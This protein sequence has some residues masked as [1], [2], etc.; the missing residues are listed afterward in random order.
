MDGI[1]KLF[2]LF[3]IELII[4]FPIVTAFTISQPV[5]NI[6]RNNVDISWNTS[7]N[8]NYSFLWDVSRTGY[9][10]EKS[11]SQFNT[12]HKVDLT[13]LISGESYSYQIIAWSNH[14]LNPLRQTYIGSFIVP[15]DNP[16]PQITGAR[17]INATL[18]YVEIEW[19]LLDRNE[20]TDLANYLIFRN[21]ENIANVT[22]SPFKD[23]KN[24]T[25]LATYIYTIAAS[26]V[27]GSIGPPSDGII[28]SIPEPDLTPPDLFNIKAIGMSNTSTLIHWT[29]NK[30]ADSTVYYGRHS[31]NMT[32]RTSGYR[33]NHTVTL[34]RLEGGNTYRY[35]VQSCDKYENCR[36][37]SQFSFLAGGSNS[38]P[39]LSVSLPSNWNA[40]IMPINGTTTPLTRVFVFVNDFNNPQF[41]VQSDLDGKFSTSVRFP[42]LVSTN[43]VLIRAMD[44]SGNTAERQF[45][46]QVD[47]TKPIVEMSEIPPLS[48]VASLPI[49][50][51]ISKDVTLNIYVETDYIGGIPPPSQVMNLVNQSVN[52]NS[53][54]LRWDANNRSEDIQFYRIYRN[55][56]AIGTSRST[57]FSDCTMP[58]T[59]YTY[60][61]AAVN[62]NCDEGAFSNTVSVR[63]PAGTNCTTSVEYEDSCSSDTPVRSIRINQGDFRQSIPL[64]EGSN[65]IRL[66]F[67]DAGGNKVEVFGTTIYDRKDPT[68]TWHNLRDLTPAY[69]DKVTVRG[70][71]DEPATVAVTVNNDSTFIGR[72][73]SNGNFSIEIELR[74]YN[75]EETTETTRAQDQIT[76]RVT[77]YSVLDQPGAEGINRQNYYS[78]QTGGVDFETTRSTWIADDGAFRNRVEIMAT[79]AVGRNSTVQR[80]DIE[81]RMCSYGSYWG[82]NLSNPMPSMLNPRHLLTGVAQVTFNFDLEWL[83]GT[84]SFVD[85][86][87]PR[88]NINFRFRRISREDQADWDVG[89]FNDPP[90][91]FMVPGSNNTQ[92]YVV[93]QSKALDRSATDTNR[94][95]RDLERA[96]RE[97]EVEDFETLLQKE[98]KISD[99]RRGSDWTNN[100]SCMISQFGCVR[101]PVQIEIRFTDPVYQ[102]NRDNLIGSTATSSGQITQ[103]QCIDFEIAI[104]RR[105]DTNVIPESF[106]RTAIKFLNNTIQLIDNLLEPLNKIKEYTLYACMGSWVVMYVKA[107]QKRWNCEFGG[108]NIKDL[109]TQ[110]G[111]KSIVAE[112]GLCEFVYAER[113]SEGGAFDLSIDDNPRLEACLK[114]ANATKDFWDWEEKMQLLCDR[115]ACPSAPSF[116]KYVRDAQRDRGRQQSV[117]IQLDGPD[118]ATD[119]LSLTSRSDCAGIELS[120]EFIQYQ[121]QI[122]KKYKEEGRDAVLFENPY[123]GVG[124]PAESNLPGV[125]GLDTKKVSCFDPRTPNPNCCVVE[126]MRKY[127]SVCGLQDGFL[128]DEMEESYCVAASFMAKDTLH[129]TETGI[130][131][132]TPDFVFG[133]EEVDV[134]GVTEERR[135]IP[136]YSGEGNLIGSGDDF[137]GAVDYDKLCNSPARRTW[138][139]L[140][141]ICE[142]NPA[143][144][145][146]IVDT[147]L[148]YATES[149]GRYFTRV[150]QTPTTQTAP[151]FAERYNFLSAQRADPTVTVHNTIHP[152]DA[153][154]FDGAHTIYIDSDCPQTLRS[155]DEH[156]I[157][158]RVLPKRVQTAAGEDTSFDIAGEFIVHRG[159]ILQNIDLDT[160]VVGWNSLLFTDGQ[161]DSPV[162]ANKVFRPLSEI[163]V[164]VFKVPEGTTIDSDS[165]LFN[166]YINPTGFAEFKRD[167]NHCASSGD[168]SRMTA[169]DRSALVRDF[170]AYKQANKDRQIRDLKE[171][172]RDD[173][174]NS[175]RVNGVT[176]S[177]IVA[178]HDGCTDDVLLR[179]CNIS[180]DTEVLS[181]EFAKIFQEYEVDDRRAQEIYLKIQ[182]AL[183]LADKEKIVDPSSSFLRSVQCLCLPGITGYLKL[184]KAI[185]TAVKACLET[186]LIT[187]DG[188]PGI[189]RAVLTRYVCDLIYDLIKC[190]ANKYSLGHQRTIGTDSTPGNI[191]GALTSAG[192]DVQRSIAGRYGSSSLFR[193]MF[194]ERQLVHA[195][196]LWAFTGTFDFD[197]NA[198]VEGEFGDIPVDSQ[199]LLSPCQR[200]F[201]SYNSANGRATWNYYFGVG[202]VAGADL[203][204]NLRLV[205][206]DGWD[207]DYGYGNERCDCADRVRTKQVYLRGA[208]SGMKRYDVLEEEAD[209]MD[210]NSEVRYDKVVLEYT[211]TNKDRERVTS[212][213]SCNIREVGG[214]AP[215]F[216]QFDVGQ[217]IYRCSLDIGHEDYAEL[218]NHDDPK[219][220]SPYW[221]PGDYLSVTAF[222]NQVLPNTLECSS[223][224]SCPSTKWLSIEIY[225]EHTNT[226]L[227]DPLAV[228]S[229]R[230]VLINGQTAYSM[231][232]SPIQL[233][234]DLVTAASTTNFGCAVDPEESWITSCTN[235]NFNSL[236]DNFILE[237][238]AN[239]V[240]IENGEACKIKGTT[241]DCI[242]D[243]NS[244]SCTCSHQGKNFDIT[245]RP[246]IDPGTPIDTTS[247]VIVKAQSSASSAVSDICHGKPENVWRITLRLYD[248]Q[249]NNGVYSISNKIHEGNSGQPQERTFSIRINCAGTS[250][251]DTSVPG[252]TTPT[253]T[254]ASFINTVSVGNQDVFSSGSKNSINLLAGTTYDVNVSSLIALAGV[255]YEIRRPDGT[256]DDWKVLQR[257]NPGSAQGWITVGNQ[258]WSPTIPG[259][260][261][262][263]V[264]ASPLGAGGNARSEVFNI[265]IS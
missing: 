247:K 41:A 99:N 189:C 105:I 252:T 221:R 61:V 240:K 235:H 124:T 110:T 186:I 209:I 195:L 39:T 158:Y 50:G 14:S 238:S 106:L 98:Q 69:D 138:N 162:A 60:Q 130:T 1:N 75:F 108:G 154:D 66:E 113:E 85:E 264:L 111:F 168:Q 17:L 243:S 119:R 25:P 74:K 259:T 250:T 176:F 234:Q 63:T 10:N 160:S 126:Y 29:T 21:G 18:D 6:D 231:P 184:W 255:T 49:N 56:R 121:Y 103:R 64:E 107:F 114:C 230:P 148:N 122:W 2:A 3:C 208:S 163:P 15:S 157:F 218:T 40:N 80:H 175:G 214:G 86:E 62:K 161:G 153:G 9:N 198:M 141:G 37:S 92:G 51:T 77:G 150:E 181:T 256:V 203:T 193:A 16:P 159:I 4:L 133:T 251:T 224:E 164:D 185:M 131:I 170:Q 197:F 191:L 136:L 19:D 263:T 128:F 201:I 33:L 142:A 125:S 104:D 76:G 187:G 140:A 23:E 139:A 78:Y 45:T 258:R 115:I 97:D 83:G 220:N 127:D 132:P 112:Q 48:L 254:F 210:T 229:Y 100:K 42:D 54:S 217:G 149:T 79:D 68:I 152:R 165:Q 117:D 57:S 27:T 93:I 205:C 109:I 169:T 95:R 87:I 215:A 134:N 225:D 84:G 242:F 241:N 120:I 116:M 226:M 59:S 236:S 219:I 38:P 36:N 245:T 46:V 102:T 260:Y 223:P 172:L 28:A 81:Y 190:V 70:H 13:G 137:L 237:V 151:T 32:A 144:N 222:V 211:Y 196:C 24:I 67:V 11:Q 145:M 91:V 216:C 8:T 123:F 177:Q 167:L 200:R 90:R 7:V 233:S 65:R 129:R 82:I 166:S 30:E 207:C 204:Y 246:S 253:D 206:S 73:D 156:G 22:R 20:V 101:L 47:A 188:N 53:V 178:G 118:G 171:E 179:D 194:A 89:W 43:Q 213:I 52:S 199:G 143:G 227:R 94:Y 71:V 262:M 183:G 248:S 244:V 202:L 147:G 146:Q 35:I 155:H 249:E 192:R 72:T 265:V 12:R 173:R 257:E 5:V 96:V 55:S 232:P 26:D 31:L 261:N 180:D 182:A 34:N 135:I 212:N 228:G 88:P 44:F 174:H 239:I 58:E